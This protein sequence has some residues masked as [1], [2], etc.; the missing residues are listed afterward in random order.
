VPF[1]LGGIERTTRVR[2]PWLLLVSVAV[3]PA[4]I[5]DMWY[6]VFEGRINSLG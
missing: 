2:E 6:W 1:Y 4:G 5:P 3:H